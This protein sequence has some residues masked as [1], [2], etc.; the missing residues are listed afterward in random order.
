MRHGRVARLQPDRDAAS[1]HGSPVRL[2][3]RVVDVLGHEVDHPRLEGGV[4]FQACG[5]S[6]S[7]LRPVGVSSAQPRQGTDVGDGVV[8]RLGGGGVR[9]RATLRVVR[10]GVRRLRLVAGTARQAADLDR[11]RGADVGARRHGRH[12]AGVE[13]ECPGARCTCAAR[14]D[15]DDD[16]H[17]RSEDI[18]DYLTHGGVQPARRIQPQDHRLR[19]ESSGLREAAGQVV[20]AGGA[21]H[22]IHMHHDHA[23]TAA[24]GR[25]SGGDRRRETNDQQKQGQ[26][27][28]QRS[29]AT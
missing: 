15:V 7:V 8:S 25:R 13:D 16:R 17:G 2:S 22:P 6:H 10:L 4:R 27:P 14:G 1:V 28:Q 26:W 24:G 29:P 9:S 23:G 12:M 5:R 19:V 21:D 3:K 18:A 20:G 11:R